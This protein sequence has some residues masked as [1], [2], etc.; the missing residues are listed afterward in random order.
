MKMRTSTQLDTGGDLRYE[1]AFG[2]LELQRYIELFINLNVHLM[3]VH[4]IVKEIKTI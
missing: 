4:K 3:V 2:P 1:H